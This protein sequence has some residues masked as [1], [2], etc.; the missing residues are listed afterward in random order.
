MIV[1]DTASKCI[2]GH[3]QEGTHM[4]FENFWKRDRERHGGDR[5]REDWRSRAGEWREAVQGGRG[6]R[7]YGRNVASGEDQDFNQR[8]WRE[9]SDYYGNRDE[10]FGGR[11]QRYQGS[12]GYGG[13]QGR[14]DY[15]MSQWRDED[16]GRD[17]GQWRGMG[18]AS[19]EYG[20]RNYTGARYGRDIS[21]ETSGGSYGMGGYGR[22]LDYG[23]RGAL[24]YG[25]YGGMGG[26]E[27]GSSIY[28]QGE[29]HRGRG[30]RGY[31]RSDER[32][33]EDICDMLTDDPYIDASNMEVTVKD[34][35]VTLSGNVSS[36]ED[37]RRAEDIA[38]RISGV[39]DVH[40]SLRVSAEQRGME[41]TGTQ[42]GQVGQTAKH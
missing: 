18:G 21:D 23:R 14:R 8:G 11:N 28:G 7:D 2:Q 5:N 30:P 27:S 35:E 36:R 37:K 25:G 6:Q 42:A 40:N 12:E 33:R 32:I 17:E 34:C 31:R 10:S 29:Q 39:K 4:A 13:G 24:G 38:E 19:R 41:Q 22:D 20:G 16:Q 15:P 26:A 3:S 9:G 1:N